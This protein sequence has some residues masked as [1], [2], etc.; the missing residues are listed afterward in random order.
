MN[1]ERDN[2][3]KSIWIRLIGSV[4]SLAMIGCFIY[5]AVVGI[6]IASTLILASAF[7]GIAAPVVIAGEG[8][9][10]CFV[11]IIEAFVE[12]VTGVLEVVG[13]VIGSIFG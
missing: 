11:G 12:G 3:K 7:S 1:V 10:E 13:D 4:S 8:F 6:D 2:S 9:M 5:I